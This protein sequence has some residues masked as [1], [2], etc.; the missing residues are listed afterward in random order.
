MAFI[1]LSLQCYLDEPMQTNAQTGEHMDAHPQES[2]AHVVRLF[3]ERC[4]GTVVGDKR[5]VCVCGRSVRSHFI[6]NE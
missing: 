5:F 6:P 2:A 1:R 3:N 4:P